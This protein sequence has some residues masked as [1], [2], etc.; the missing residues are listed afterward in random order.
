MLKPG[1]GQ[2]ELNQSCH[3]VRAKEEK[4]KSRKKMYSSIGEQAVQTYTFKSLDVLTEIHIK[5]AAFI[6][7][8]NSPIFIQYNSII[9]SDLCPF[10]MYI[11]M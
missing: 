5:F 1:R 9:H 3:F 10:H 11:Q 8:H 6:P 2:A 4:N 7:I